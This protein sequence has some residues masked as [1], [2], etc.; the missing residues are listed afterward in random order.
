MNY[1]Y[2]SL[3]ISIIFLISFVST[4]ICAHPGHGSEYIEEVP[5]SQAPSTSEVQSSSSGSGHSSSQSSS[6]QSSYGG[7]WSFK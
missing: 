1:K 6:S 3:L 5:S 4:A 7:V 2:L